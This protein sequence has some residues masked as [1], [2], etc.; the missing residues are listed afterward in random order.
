[1]PRC[2]ESLNGLAIGY[3]SA[4]GAGLASF[5]SPCVLPL[6]PAY[7]SFLA[8]V[9]YER[10]VEPELHAGVQ[11]RLL[12]AAVAFVFG[13]VVVF[14]SFG[15]SATLI[16]R[17]LTEQ[18]ALLA[19]I[20]GVLLIALG[21]VQLGFLR[22]GAMQRDIRFH[23]RTLPVGPAGAFVMGLAFAFGWTPCV[24]PILAAI[25]T[26]AANERSVTQGVVLLAFYGAGI[27][28]PFIAAAL[29]FA[30]FTRLLSHL[31]E[32]MRIVEASV[33]ALMVAT[34]ALIFTGNLANVGGWLMQTFPA[35]SRVG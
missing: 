14:V 25:L 6:V 24:G 3:A 27:G 1:V 21:L 20:S 15:A 23:P 8:G 5:I 10:A 9:S 34:G 33:G 22:L 4:F 31:R 12:I 29:A 11:R 18:G 28:I 32:R 30:P 26:I 7:L 2:H 35:F 13:F 19:R 16:G 17:V